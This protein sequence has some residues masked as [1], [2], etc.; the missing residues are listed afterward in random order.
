[1]NNVF[2]NEFKHAKYPFINAT[3]EEYISPSSLA[4]TRDGSRFVAGSLNRISVFDAAVDGSGPISEHKT[5]A[6]RKEKKLYGAEGKRGCRG[7]VSALSMSS[8]GILAAGTLDR[9]IGLYA[10]QGSGE[11]VTAF[12]I[13]DTFDSP[14]SLRGVGITHLAWSSDGKYLLAAERRSDVIQVYDVRNT[15]QR[16]AWLSGR[17]ADTMQKLGI[18]VVPTVSGYEAWAGGTD[19]CVRM[20]KY[21]GSIEGDHAPDGEFKAHNG[22]SHAIFVAISC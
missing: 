9:Q 22:K 19:G 5:A 21:A 4:W 13:A 10:N 1:M 7:I 11:C 2:Y 20:W 18:D 16:V 15:M 6:G 8:D 12:S 14:I 17:K 3:T